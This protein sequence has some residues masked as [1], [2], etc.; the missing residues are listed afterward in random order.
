MVAKLL[1]RAEIISASPQRVPVPTDDSPLPPEMKSGMGPD[2][3]YDDHAR[4]ARN[5]A[6]SPVAER[7][8]PSSL[9]LP[10]TR[11][12]VILTPET[13]LST[14]HL[15]ARPAR[16]GNRILTIGLVR[17]CLGLFGTC[18]AW[19]NISFRTLRAGESL[20]RLPTTF[21]ILGS[22]QVVRT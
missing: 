20:I 14:K 6:E 16:Q 5:Q 21:P 4:A 22:F 1:G 10:Q 19:R 3:V 12:L 8:K 9:H 7:A 18:F 2:R 15:P 17:Y 13:S 11:N